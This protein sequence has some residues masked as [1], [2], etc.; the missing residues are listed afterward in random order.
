[1][2]SLRRLLARLAHSTRIALV[3]IV[4]LLAIAA[5]A[6][7]AA[8]TASAATMPAE[9]IF[10]N[11][12]LDTNAN[13]CIQRLQVMHQGGVNVVLFPATQGSLQNLAG[14]AAAANSMGMKVMWQLSNPGWWQNASVASYYPSF[15]QACGCTTNS[16]LLPYMVHFFASLPGTYGYYAA[17]DS[18]LGSG[19]R[20]G[21]A[22]YVSSIKTV[23]P[24]HTVILS[25]SDESQASQYQ[26]IGD[27][28]AAEIYPVTNS[29][30]LPIG[31]NIAQWDGVAQSA[32]D[33]QKMAT[34]AG[35][36]SAFILQAF[37]WGDN[38]DD[39][40]G[41]GVCTAADTT[42]SCWNKLQY[43]AAAAQL[44]LRDEILQN[45]HPKLIIWWSF[46]GTYGQS[47]GDTYSIYPTGA[48]A[49]AHWAGL[50]AAI[51]APAPAGMQGGATAHAASAK[52]HIARSTRK[53]HRKVRRHRRTTRRH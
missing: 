30:L 47:G 25:S 32:I 45:A 27:M 50:K 5:V 3:A 53:H 35:K 15:A 1:M 23:D 43:P 48:A 26:S 2:P 36:A 42:Q 29:S 6:G 20:T 44:K 41:I 12:N 49:A 11:C 13:L 18:M 38:I 8:A 16:A 52:A 46:Q 21:V 33:A 40:Q 31:G 37:S 22:Q 39:G 28:N 14:Y 19:D 4:S 7:P 24:H 10:E 34:K 9:G 51:N 17:D